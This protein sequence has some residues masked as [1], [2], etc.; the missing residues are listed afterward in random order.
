DSLVIRKLLETTDAQECALRR[1]EEAWPAA[2]AASEEVCSLLVRTDA[3]EQRLDCI[4]QDDNEDKFAD[5]ADRTELLRVEASLQEL[6]D[7]LRRLSQRTANSESRAAALER[8]PLGALFTVSDV[9]KSIESLCSVFS[10]VP[11]FHIT[12]ALAHVTSTIVL[13]SS[14]IPEMVASISRSPL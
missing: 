6:S 5:K 3:L 13:E 1:L 11:E 8:S 10:S 4:Q 7:P 2:G 12:F 14:A 9:A